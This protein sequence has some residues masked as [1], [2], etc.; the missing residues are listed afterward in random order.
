[1]SDRIGQ[2]LHRLDAEA[3][4]AI[5]ATHAPALDAPLA[6][7]SRA[8]D[9]SKL[10]L[11]GA[12]VLALAGGPRGR[13]A[14]ASG[15]AAIGVTSTIVN[16]GLKP[17]GRRARPDRTAHA[18][19]AGRHVAMPASTS[20]PSGHAASAF[21]FATGVAHVAP[22]AG[23]VA[24]AAAALVAYSRV[25]TG[26]HYPGDVVAGSLTGVVLGKATAELLQ[27]RLGD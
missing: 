12:G 26:V 17:L 1:M 4:A 7:V 14:A 23:R 13:R 9:L 18:V 19:P 5:A 24:R 2:V 21:A 10:W 8:A 6:A 15:L 25:H 20:F 27:R 11:A 22:R 3:Y 16:L